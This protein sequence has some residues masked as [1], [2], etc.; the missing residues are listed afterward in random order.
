MNVVMLDLP[1]GPLMGAPLSAE[2][3]TRRACAVVGRHGATG[4][5]SSSSSL[6]QA[7]APSPASASPP[8]AQVIDNLTARRSFSHFPNPN[9]LSLQLSC[10]YRLKRHPG[11]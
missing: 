4:A 9:R 3:L 5:Q 8:A 2:P 10:R 6:A 7:P 11:H 1:Q